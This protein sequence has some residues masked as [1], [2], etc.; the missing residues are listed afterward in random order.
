LSFFPRLTLVLA[1][2]PERLGAAL[3]G[4]HGVWTLRDG[5][6]GLV[7]L[8]TAISDGAMC[9]NFPYVAVHPSYQGR[10]WGRRLMETALA[11]YRG[12]HHVALISYGDKAGFY[13]R[14]GFERDCEKAVL[15][16][17]DEANADR[18]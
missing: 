3:A 11:R 9:V 6:L 2:F 8:C 15:F 5:D 1:R 13:E 12:F 14:V 7:G 17:R 4:S 18:V 10:G 16:A